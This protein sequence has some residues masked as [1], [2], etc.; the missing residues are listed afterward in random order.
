[1]SVQYSLKSEPGYFHPLTLAEISAIEARAT[2]DE[3]IVFDEDCPPS[4]PE[5]LKQFRRVHPRSDPI[6]GSGM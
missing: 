4:T 3:D 2:R 5:Q 1:M 6:V